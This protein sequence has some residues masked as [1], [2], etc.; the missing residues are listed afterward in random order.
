MASP[1][2]ADHG[3]AI[4]GAAGRFPGASNLSQY[5]QN[6]CAGVESIKHLSPTEIE[7]SGVAIGRRRDANYV[8]AAAMIDNVDGFDAGFF[9][10]SAR[11]AEVTDPQHR[12]LLECAWAALDDAG[13]CPD[14]YP[15]RVGV[16][17]GVGVN[18]YLLDVCRRGALSLETPAGYQAFIGNDK[19]FLA[20][21]ISYK[22]NLRGP[23]L[24]LQTACSTSLVAVHYACESLYGG[25]CDLA[26]AGAVS[27]STGSVS[28]YLYQEG[29]ILSQD[30]HCRAFDAGASGR[31]S[32]AARV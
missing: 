7:R 22:L 15:G 4:I 3:I 13:Y 16:F 12:I 20:T 14:D 8:P 9:G 31:C 2:D 1:N 5:W 6:L 19:D 18:S 11:E 27:V 25:E 23:S 10:F 21:R 32:G 30:G 29:A 28:G 24:T 17:A 26:L